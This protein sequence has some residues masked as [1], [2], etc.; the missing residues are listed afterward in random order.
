MINWGKK[1]IFQSAV[2]AAFD[3]KNSARAAGI[4]GKAK[5]TAPCGLALG[6]RL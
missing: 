4:I 2:S 3:G 5:N 1:A 6:T